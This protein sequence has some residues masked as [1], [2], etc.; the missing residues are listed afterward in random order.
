MNR[1]L[2]K[3]AALELAG[4]YR[5]TLF[6]FLLSKIIHLTAHREES[7]VPKQKECY[8]CDAV[9]VAAVTDATG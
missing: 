4:V 6:W 8:V 7:G 3:A 1:L 2:T 9:P 5:C